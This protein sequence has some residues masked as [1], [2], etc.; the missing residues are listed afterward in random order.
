MVIRNRRIQDKGP[1]ICW[2]IKKKL[3]EF[4]M[5]FYTKQG[6]IGNIASF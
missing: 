4:K 1:S 6:E 2:I 3:S 5:K